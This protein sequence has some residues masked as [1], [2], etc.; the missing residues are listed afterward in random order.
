MSTWSLQDAKARFSEL[1]QESISTGPQI[2][3]RR[4]KD[5]VVVVSVDQFSKSSKSSSLLDFF[6]TAPKTD[7]P[8][9]RSADP[10]RPFS[11]E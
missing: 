11:F 8:I 1:V 2:V 9:I 6:L 3:T 7:L 5:A 4:G 10:V